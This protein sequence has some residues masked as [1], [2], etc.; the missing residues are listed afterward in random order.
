M[1]KLLHVLHLVL[2]LLQL[3]VSYKVLLLVYYQDHYISVYLLY[4]QVV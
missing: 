1:Y 2:K 3:M 4:H